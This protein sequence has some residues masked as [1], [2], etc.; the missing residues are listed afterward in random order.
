M[1]EAAPSPDIAFDAT[2][3][4]LETAPLLVVWAHGWG[5]DR[6]AFRPL[7]ETLATRAAHLLVDFPVLVSRR[8][9]PPTWTTADYADAVAA[10]LRPLR[11]GKKLIWAGHSFGCRVGF[12][13]RRGIR[14]LSMGFFF[15]RARG[16]NV[17]AACGKNSTM[18][19]ASIFL[20]RSSI[21]RRSWAT[22]SINCAADSAAPI[23]VMQA[24]CGKY[25]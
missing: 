15:L 21:S 13:W 20:K 25:S 18:G 19:D 2:G 5:M 10:W 7:A 22:A 6:K 11:A 3:L 4:P 1:A 16:F 9:P 8:C 14:I 12:N 17:N 23:T 24:P